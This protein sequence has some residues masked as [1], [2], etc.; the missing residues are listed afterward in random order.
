M[1]EVI[2]NIEVPGN[3]IL[4]DSRIPDDYLTEEV[5]SELIEELELPRITADEQ[6]ITYSLFHV[7]SNQNLLAG[8]TLPEA[9]V[10]NGDTIRLLSSHDV[11]SASS[12][13]GQA[14]YDPNKREIEV[15][16]SVL[17]LNK[18]EHVSL[19]QDIK[20]EEILSKITDN[21]NLPPRDKL[22]SI[23]TYRLRS[24]SL[25]RFLYNSETLQQ[26]GIP[27]LDLITIHRD[28]IAGGDIYW[29]KR[30]REAGKIAYSIPVIPEWSTLRAIRRS[31]SAIARNFIVRLK[32]FALPLGVYYDPVDCT[33]FAPPSVSRTASCLIQIFAHRP[34]HVTTVSGMAKEFDKDAERRG[35]RSLGMEVA[36]GTKLTFHLTVPGFEVEDAIQSVIWQGTPTLVQFDLT[37]PYNQ[38]LGDVIGTVMVSYEQIPLGHIKFKI[39]VTQIKQSSAELEPVGFAYV[40]RKAFISYASQDR[41]EVLKRVQMLARLRIKTFQDVLSLEPGVRW[42]KALYRHIDDSDLFLLFWSSAAKQS[43][44]VMKEV[45]YALE[46]KQDDLSPPEIIPILIEGPPPVPPPEELAH[47]HFN[48][49]FLYLMANS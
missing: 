10:H 26:A 38:N 34:E 11:L 21:Y 31:L 19:S 41:L 1:S 20:I 29:D 22:G 45:R 4:E 30:K 25:G 24:K 8:K 40:Y 43:E 18:T 33:V 5:I 13:E 35:F 49:Y 36:R 27:L 46:L 37:V 7:Q 47:L 15:V 32:Q 9:G 3:M 14:N 39:T 28:E 44:W 23:I 42:E 17:D 6:I 12:I 2:V 48:D 16:L